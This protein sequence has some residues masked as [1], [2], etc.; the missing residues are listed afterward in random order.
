VILR[1]RFTWI[2]VSILG[3]LVVAACGGGGSS[4]NSS[5]A[6]P[7]AAPAQAAPAAA[8]P[9]VDAGQRAGAAA[10][11]AAQGTQPAAV[12]EPTCQVI[13]SADRP[14]A[15]VASIS[16]RVAQAPPNPQ[17]LATAM[18]DQ[19]LEVTTFKDGFTRGAFAQ[20][21]PGGNQS[22][23]FS[24]RGAPPTALPGLTALTVTKVS[25][26]QERLTSGSPNPGAFTAP[27]AGVD[28]TQV[29]VVEIEGLEP[30]LNYYWRRTPTGP[31]VRCQAPICPA[32]ARGRQ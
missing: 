20:L 8:A 11:A 25:T 9:A 18:S 7:A 23:A 32:D 28:P 29:V 16:W 27:P 17:A 5:Q 3:L 4:S 19:R 21:A 13:C 10:P 15:A 12:G 24:A 2:S 26:A 14:R 1:T 30:G 22:F 31:V 6:E